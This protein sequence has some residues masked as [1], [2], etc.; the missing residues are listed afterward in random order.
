MTLKQTKDIATF[1]DEVEST[2]R[3]AG[4]DVNDEVV[5]R[6]LKNKVKPK[7]KHDLNLLLACVYSE[8]QVDRG[9]AGVLQSMRQVQRVYDRVAVA[10]ITAPSCRG[11]WSVV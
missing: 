6:I 5:M 4:V 3:A 2:A 11:I 9:M 10:G 8:V 7:L 1:R